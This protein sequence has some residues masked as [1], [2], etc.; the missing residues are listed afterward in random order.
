MKLGYDL[1]GINK[2]TFSENPVSDT[3]DLR[4]SIN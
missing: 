3:I 2:V 1:D 4:P